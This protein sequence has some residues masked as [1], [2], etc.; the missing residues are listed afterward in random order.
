MK[1]YVQE[2][3]LAIGDPVHTRHGDGLVSGIDSHE[4]IV[5]VVLRGDDTAG[6]W[7]LAEEVT[8]L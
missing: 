4:G 1:R 8:A 7:Y 3:P 2:R 5:Q 6:S